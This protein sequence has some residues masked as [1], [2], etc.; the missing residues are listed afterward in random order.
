MPLSLDNIAIISFTIFS[1]ISAAA[2]CYVRWLEGRF[3]YLIPAEDETTQERAD[4]NHD[5]NV[6]Y[7]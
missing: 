3:V 2:S 7:F 5:D 1:S 4:Y 6:T